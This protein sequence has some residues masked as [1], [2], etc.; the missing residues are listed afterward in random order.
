MR[1][2]FLSALKDLR[3]MRR[4]P[5]ALAAW[6]GSPLLIALL[7]V[8][9]FGH[10]QPKP[11]GLV[12][13]ADQ[14]KT[15]LSAIVMHAY[16][17]DELGEMLTVQQVPLEEGRRRIN[18]GDGSALVIIPKGFS[19]AVFGRGTAKVELITNPSQSILPEIAESVTSILVESAWRLQQIVGDDLDQFAGDTRPSDE[20]IAESSVRYSHLAT[21]LRRYLD[22]LVIKVAVGT[23]EE[24]PGRNRINIGQAMFPSMTFMA[25]LF[26]AAGLAGDLWKEKVAGT[27]RH[28]AV[29]PGSMA[30]F[31][32]GKLLALWA[33]FAVVGIVSLLAG[34]LLIRAEIHSAVLAVL[35]ITVSGGALYM[36]FVLLH[37]SFSNPRGATMLS[38]LLM[39]LLGMLG[40]CFFPFELMPHSLTSVGR[41][42]PNGRALLLFR[43]ILSGQAQPLKITIAFLIAGGITAA[44]FSVAARRM[45]RKYIY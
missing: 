31:I 26:L 6:I 35:W 33:V 13:I 3:R 10:K 15:L 32:G 40:G 11:Q 1:F 36:L 43:D 8:A 39:M 25:L 34:K 22:P 5:M 24:N 4:D 42:T 28:V 9:F 30:G 21:D 38:N 14:D 20:A 12:M 37:T 27:L 23:A 29:T 41:W 18:S 44:L 7:L 17:Q 16:T 2:V 19:K 45:R